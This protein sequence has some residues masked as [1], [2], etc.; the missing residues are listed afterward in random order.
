MERARKAKADTVSQA[1]PAAGQRSPHRARACSALIIKFLFSSRHA[2]PIS[3]SLPC[4]EW[5]TPCL[6]AGPALT[7]QVWSRIMQVAERDVH[8][9]TM[10]CQ[11]VLQLPLLYVYMRVC[12]CVLLCKSSVWVRAQ[13]LSSSLTRRSGL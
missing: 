13:W 9:A 11:K 5:I 2:H 10:K 7:C 8:I 4:L 3:L 12:V 6:L 1:E